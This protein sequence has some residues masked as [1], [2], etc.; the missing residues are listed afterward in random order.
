MHTMGF[1]YSPLGQKIGTSLSVQS[2][3]GSNSPCHSHDYLGD[4]GQSPSK[5]DARSQQPFSTS[6]TRLD[7]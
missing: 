6:S 2:R 3:G 4:G 5:E 1:G 7:P